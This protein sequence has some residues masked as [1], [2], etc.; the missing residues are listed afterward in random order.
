MKLLIRICL[1][2]SLN[3]ERETG[4]S[5]GLRRFIDRVNTQNDQL[6]MN[7]TAEDSAELMKYVYRSADQCPVC[8]KPVEDKCARRGEHV[9]HLQSCMTCKNC[10][11]DLAENLTD[12]RWDPHRQAVLCRNCS[13]WFANIESGFELVT[14]LQQYVHLLK[15]AHARLL[16]NVTGLA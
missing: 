10:G 8:D 12:A 4:S 5:E 1:Q 11:I 13:I 15:V 9:Y 6:E 3:L 14:R 2:E 16:A 7:E